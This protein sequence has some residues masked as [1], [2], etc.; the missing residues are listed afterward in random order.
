MYLHTVL[1]GVQLSSGPAAHLRSV[2]A[3]VPAVLEAKGKE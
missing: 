2:Y 3:L 1:T